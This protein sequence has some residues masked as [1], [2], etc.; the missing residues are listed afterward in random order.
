MAFGQINPAMMDSI[1]RD[2]QLESHSDQEPI[3][4]V[5][6]EIHEKNEEMEENSTTSTETVSE[7]DDQHDS[8]SNEPTEEQPSKEEMYP[9][10]TQV[11]K[12]VYDTNN[13]EKPQITEDEILSEF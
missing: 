13:E 6:K 9:N 4:T 7:H 2:V 10:A 11:V 3:D 5:A 1:E 8:C 12:I